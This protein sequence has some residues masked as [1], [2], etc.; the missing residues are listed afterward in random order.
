MY[1]LEIGTIVLTSNFARL[2]SLKTGQNDC[3]FTRNWHFFT[4]YMCC[5][6][7]QPAAPT[8]HERGAAYRGAMACHTAWRWDT[9]LDDLLRSEARGGEKRRSVASRWRKVDAESC[10]NKGGE[11]RMIEF[12]GE[13]M[14]CGAVACVSRSFQSGC[15]VS[16]PSTL[17]LVCG[18]CGDFPVSR[19]QTLNLAETLALNSWAHGPSCSVPPCSAILAP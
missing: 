18:T 1:S 17:V 5:V 4:E 10:F 19:K 12:A 15:L 11:P 13:F 14:L 6:C 7:S 2:P 9:S 8:T 16:R 3:T